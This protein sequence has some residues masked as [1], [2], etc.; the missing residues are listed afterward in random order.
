MHREGKEPASSIGQD[1]FEFLYGE[2]E[3]Q[4]DCDASDLDDG[5]VER[6]ILERVVHEKRHS[7][8]PD[9]AGREKTVGVAVAPFVEVPIRPCGAAF[10]RHR[11][12]VGDALSGNRLGS[13]GYVPDIQLSGQFPVAELVVIPGPLGFRSMLF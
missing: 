6:Q 7:I 3:V 2:S 11:G 1:E 9:R 4:P 5:E 12:G 8:S 13:A 10:E